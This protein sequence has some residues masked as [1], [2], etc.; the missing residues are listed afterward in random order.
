MWALVDRSTQETHQK[1]KRSPSE[2][3][4]FAPRRRWKATSSYGEIVKELNYPC[5]NA[6]AASKM[7]PQ[8]RATPP[9]PLTDLIFTGIIFGIIFVN[10]INE[11]IGLERELEFVNV[12]VKYECKVW[13]IITNTISCTT[14]SSNNI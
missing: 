1:S 14:S 3:D 12:N 9:R 8:P 7:I 2:Q 6:S 13:C 4:S 11:N 10:E 5:H